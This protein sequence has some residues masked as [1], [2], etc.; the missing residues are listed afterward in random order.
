MSGESVRTPN[1][2]RWLP[3]CPSDYRETDEPSECGGRPTLLTTHNAL[4]TRTH[5]SPTASI[6]PW[7]TNIS[8]ANLTIHEHFN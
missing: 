4:L 6:L 5:D 7:R 2:P 1:L 8:S 3:P